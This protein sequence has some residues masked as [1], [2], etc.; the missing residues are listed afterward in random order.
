MTYTSGWQAVGSEP[1]TLCTSAYPYECVGVLVNALCEQWDMAYEDM[2]G[3]ADGIYAPTYDA[4]HHSRIPFAIE[5]NGVTYW[6]KA[7]A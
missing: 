6:V 4:L 1:V 7:N 5:C 3:I 2:G